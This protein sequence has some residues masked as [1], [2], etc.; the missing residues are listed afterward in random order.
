MRTWLYETI[1]EH[2][3]RWGLVFDISL[4]VAILV[5]IAVVMLESVG[6]INAEYGQALRRIE[7]ILTALFTAEYIARL[8]CH[9]HPRVYAR[10]FFGMVDLLAIVPTFITAV[11]PGAHALAV[12]RMLRLLRVF[13]ILKLAQFVGQANELGGAL[14]ASL[15]KITVFMIAVVSM[16]TISG[17]L[18]YLI[19]G[20]E[21]GF[22]SIPES[23]YWAIV[24]LTTVGYGDI[25]PE[26]PLGKGMA[27]IIMVLGYGVIAVPT[28][29]VSS[30]I[31]KATMLRPLAGQACSSCGSE[32][33]AKGASFCDRCGTSL[34]E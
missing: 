11:F 18:L 14:R 31:S 23:V 32:D 19:E 25:S 34:D 26:T 12:V 16:T 9:P 29:I 33:H 28:G 3:T 20:E 6:S 21:H 8:S 10:S 15:P 22:T 2:D 5:S 17:T 7:W 1:F 13:R 24:T 4:L 30:E 27:S